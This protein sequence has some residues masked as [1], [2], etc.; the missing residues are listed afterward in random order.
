MNRI[1]TLAADL[2]IDIT[3]CRICGSAALTDCMVFG[4]QYL[5]TN[6]VASN[7]EHPL[8]KLKVPLT[9]VLCG[10]CGLVQ[11]K[12]SVNR[13]I[14][15]RDY[16]YRSG[17]NPMMRTALRDVVE[18][19]SRHQALKNGDFVL[20]IGC[21]DCTA[22]S[23][24]PPECRRIGVEPATN[25]NWSDVDESIHIINDFFSPTD[26]MKATGGI[27]CNAITSIAMM[28]NVEDLNVFSS[29]VKSILAPSGIWCI[30]L[31]YL[32]TLIDNLSFYDVCHEHLYYFS[33][34]TLN[35]LL[36]RNGLSI[37]DASLNDTNGGSLRVFVTHADRPRPKTASVHNVIEEERRL[38][39][40]D[41][42]T[43]SKFF[44][45]V[46][47]I[48]KKIRGYLY[49]E[50]ERG[51]LVIGLGASTKGNV[52]LQFFGIDKV[53]L[54]YIGDRNPEKV[55]LR[56]LGTDIEVISEEQ[57]RHLRPSCM[58]VLIWYFKD[59]II[60]RE[61]DYLQSGGQLLFPMPNCCIVD[62]DGEWAIETGTAV[63]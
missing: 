24:F 56:T 12:E 51:N 2:Y 57:A 53:A 18:D 34:T 45:E 25:I 36:E 1:V 47:D 17:T 27:P 44:D 30:Q 61:Q 15:F 5:A 32:P 55:S 19:V 21:N 54:P 43:Y 42:E 14:L 11:L 9:V 58:L 46:S 4:E 31:S 22:L 48:R 50:A 8:A 7:E 40:N 52:L 10:D 6:F 26:V 29:N 63:Q 33:L 20:D 35:K 41:V 28:Y 37:Y 23:Y 16:F 60:K 13:S 62:K 38:G 49:R 59:E 3:H 39:L